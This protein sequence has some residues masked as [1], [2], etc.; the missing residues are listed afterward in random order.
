[1]KRVRRVR[2]SRIIACQQDEAKII[3][4]K[5]YSEDFRWQENKASVSLL[6]ANEGQK[7]I[8]Q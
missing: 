7:Y 3:L 8:A 2:A 6:V 5:K 1:M 4:S